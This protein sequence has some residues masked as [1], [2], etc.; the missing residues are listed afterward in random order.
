MP[1]DKSEENEELG[2]EELEEYAEGDKSIWAKGSFMQSISSEEVKKKER[3]IGMKHDEEMN[4]I[5]KKCGKK[6]SAHNKD[7][8][9]GMCDDCFNKTYFNE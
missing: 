8:H 5:C 7:W 6:I 4:F 9:D 1:K 3:T 2:E